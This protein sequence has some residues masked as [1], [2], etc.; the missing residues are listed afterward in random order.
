[1]EK[2]VVAWWG[3]RG[4]KT[5]QNK[6]HPKSQCIFVQ[7]FLCSIY[8]EVPWKQTGLSPFPSCIL[9]PKLEIHSPKT[10]AVR[11][12]SSWE[13]A[14]VTVLR[15]VRAR[16][17]HCHWVSTPVPQ[18][19]FKI[20]SFHITQCTWEASSV[21]QLLHWADWFWSYRVDHVMLVTE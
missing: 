16:Q 20:G 4:G 6:T 8:Q 5:P 19:G 13:P 7:I 9:D 12:Q 11:V 15:P 21:L 17:V 3:H 1:M 2:G 18:V 10:G 14:L